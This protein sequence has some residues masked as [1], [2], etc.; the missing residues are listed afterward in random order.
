ML[1]CG[2]VPVYYV[3]QLFEISIC[4]SDVVDGDSQLGCS[5]TM[6]AFFFVANFHIHRHKEEFEIIV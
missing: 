1:K 4:H 5:G 6:M 2:G 3:H